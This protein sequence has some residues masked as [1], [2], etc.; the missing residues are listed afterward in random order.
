MTSTLI[1]VVISKFP[2]FYSKSGYF[3]SLQREHIH[4][5]ILL[6]MLTATS[7]KD[8]DW[9][10][11]IYLLLVER[12]LKSQNFLSFLQGKQETGNFRN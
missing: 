1:F 12:G 5:S 11:Q 6:Y 8:N 10:E 7:E 9:H 2:L 4:F 3:I